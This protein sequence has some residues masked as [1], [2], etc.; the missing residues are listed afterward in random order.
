MKFYMTFSTIRISP[1]HFHENRDNIDTIH[2]STHMAIPHPP[3]P[4]N[5][6]NHDL[7]PRWKE[8]DFS[9]GDLVEFY[10]CL[11]GHM[12]P[13]PPEYGIV[14]FASGGHMSITVK[15][16][17]GK[18]IRPRAVNVCVSQLYNVRVLE[19]YEHS[20]LA[21]SLKEGCQTQY[22][23]IREEKGKR[24]QLAVSHTIEKRIMDYP[25]EGKSF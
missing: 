19:T 7:T 2:C 10:I 6:G 3:I 22:A 4:E 13:S 8:G 12:Q 17:S 5:Y 18:D 25:R 21:A 16:I 1:V 9:V 11:D 24:K 23:T 15:C 14:A 20:K